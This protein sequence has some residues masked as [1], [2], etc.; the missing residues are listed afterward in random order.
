MVRTSQFKLAHGLNPYLFLVGFWAD[1]LNALL[2]LNESYL[3]LHD[4]QSIWYLAELDWLSSPCPRSAIL[5][6]IRARQTQKA[7]DKTFVFKLIVYLGILWL[8]ERRQCRG[9]LISVR[10]CHLRSDSTPKH[11]TN[12]LI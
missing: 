10:L 9:V 6:V 2:S 5:V 11:Y 7:S 8:F 1:F 4:H 3:Y 12:F